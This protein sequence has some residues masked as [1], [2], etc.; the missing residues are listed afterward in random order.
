MLEQETVSVINVINEN[1]LGILILCLCFCRTYFSCSRGSNTL[2]MNLLYSNLLHLVCM[3]QWIPCKKGC[4][5][6]LC[7]KKRHREIE[8]FL[9]ICHVALRYNAVMTK[10]IIL[11]CPPQKNS[12]DHVWKV[13]QECRYEKALKY[14]SSNTC[15]A[16]HDALH[17]CLCNCYLWIPSDN[18]VNMWMRNLLFLSYSPYLPW[19]VS[20]E[21]EVC[22]IFRIAFV[23]KMKHWDVHFHQKRAR[24]FSELLMEHSWYECK[25]QKQVA[26]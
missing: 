9:L 25:L 1:I 15:N 13:C 12:F 6:S 5:V 22:I 17:Y 10:V 23:M 20:G 14:N 7:R 11:H 18:S 8:S 2:K 3:L 21:H 4:C 16:E 26:G 19:S 24:P